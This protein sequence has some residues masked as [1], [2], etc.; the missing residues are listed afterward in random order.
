MKKII[1][2]LIFF[3]FAGCSSK[4]TPDK[5]T[6]SV[7]SVFNLLIE[8]P[9]FVMYFNFS[10]MRST[11]FWKDN[12]SDSILNSENTLGSLLNTFKEATGV[13]ISQ[14]LDELYYT[15]SW[16]GENAFVLK[17]VFDKN[18]LNSFI[19]KDSTFAVK[20]YPDGITVYIKKDNNLQFFLK[21]NI[22]LCASNFTSQIENMIS[23]KDTSYSGLLLNKSVITAIEKINHKSNLWLVTT[24]KTFIRGIFLNFV[25]S[26]SPKLDTAKSFPNDTLKME[27]TDSLTKTDK[28]IAD[29]LYKQINSVSLS[30]KMKNELDVAVQFECV[31]D[32]S[33]GFLNKLITGMITLS[34][35]SPS[36]Q[37]DKK[38]SAPE[39]ILE[40]LK[41][42]NF[43]SSVQIYINITKDNIEDFRKNSFLT[44][45]N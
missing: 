37:N 38:P 29:E 12:I 2:I 9:Q 22:T 18:R 7:K 30:A 41:V 17:G 36:G 28:M 19:K 32:A 11:G 40:S 25:E 14:G 31:D 35:L 8:K 16:Q 33:A 34:K 21:D 42:N 44:K 27:K 6:P 5:L 3:I 15:N 23:V 4:P 20:D 13:S 43:E 39:K 10:N 1:L 24:E 45:P 26:K